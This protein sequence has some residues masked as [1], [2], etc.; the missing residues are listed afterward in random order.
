MIGEPDAGNPHVRFD[1]GTQ[2]TCVLAARLSP[3]LQGGPDGFL[4]KNISSEYRRHNR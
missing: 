2:E 4:V 1:E 3:T